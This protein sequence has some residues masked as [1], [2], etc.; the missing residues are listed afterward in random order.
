MQFRICYTRGKSMVA[1]LPTQMGVRSGAVACPRLL[2][3]ITL[4]RRRLCHCRHSPGRNPPLGSIAVYLSHA[5]HRQRP[6]SEPP[7]TGPTLRSCAR[8]HTTSS[9]SNLAP[10]R[11]IASEIKKCKQRTRDVD[12]EKGGCERR[13]NVPRFQAQQIDRRS[14]LILAH[15]DNLRLCS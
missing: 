6:R 8:N 3:T 11:G 9:V 5:R 2:I 14:W 10:S 15:H 7:P 4:A 12:P 13:M 1:A